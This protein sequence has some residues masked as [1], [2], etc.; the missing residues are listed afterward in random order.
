M[1]MPLVMIIEDCSA[2]IAGL[3]HYVKNSGGAII[4]NNFRDHVL[5]QTKA[6]KFT[7]LESHLVCALW[8]F[9]ANSL[10]N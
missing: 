8:D 5:Q 4:F 2:V 6:A 1:M 10:C 3:F 9:T 7:L